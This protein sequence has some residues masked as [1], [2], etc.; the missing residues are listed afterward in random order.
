MAARSTKAEPLAD[1][2]LSDIGR[3]IGVKPIGQSITPA[4][5]SC[6]RGFFARSVLLTSTWPTCIHADIYP[7]P[8]SSGHRHRILFS[9]HVHV[10]ASS[11]RTEMMQRNPQIR[12]RVPLIIMRCLVGLLLPGA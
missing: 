12:K 1:S 8:P 4:S 10:D 7:L 2:S 6:S 11:V 3:G 9:F 5:G